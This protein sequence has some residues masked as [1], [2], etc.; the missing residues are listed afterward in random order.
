VT[1]AWL[2]GSDPWGLTPFVGLVVFVVLA[3]GCG[4]GEQAGQEPLGRA[5]VAKTSLTPSAHL[6]AEP[7]VAR[8]DV[9]VDRDQV[10]P[11]R[12]RVKPGFEPYEIVGGVVR[13]REDFGS[14]TRL[15]Y[16]FTLRCLLIECIP[17]ILQSAAG[18][19]ESGR[20]ERRTFR[21]KPA[22]VLYENPDAEPRTLRNAAWPTLEAISRINASEIPRF[23][24]VFRTSVTPLPDV[25]YS[26]SP[27]FLGAGLIAGALALLALPAG[28]AAGWLRRR[29][30]EPIEEE[31]ELPPLEQALLLV[32]WARDR[33]NGADRRKALEVLAVELDASRQDTLA[34]AARSLAWAQTSPTPDAAATL[35]QAV[36]EADG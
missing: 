25:T 33:E 16:E 36:R 1:K 30:P 13:T 26:A 3:A 23:G 22:S 2:S 11:G 9:V 28:L 34:D 18:D 20:G 10:D 4:S 32:E 17:A 27:T 12:V 35:V 15:R 7:V 19:D 8:L 24:F 21:F 14:V 31:P 6:F 5:V 29:R